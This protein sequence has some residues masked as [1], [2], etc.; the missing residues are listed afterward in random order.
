MSE[1]ELLILRRVAR[2]DLLRDIGADLFLST[3]GVHSVLSRMYGR[4]GATSTR[5]SL[6]RRGCLRRRGW[7]STL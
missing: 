3:N 2:G 1:R 7:Q 4:L 6:G 5:G